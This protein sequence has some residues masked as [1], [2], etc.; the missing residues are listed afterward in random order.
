VAPPPLSVA[1]GER[2]VLFVGK[3]E[4]NKGAH[5]LLE[6]LRALRD[7]VRNDDRRQT[8]EDSGPWSVVRGPSSRVAVL[9]SLVIAGSGPLRAELERGLAALGVP[10]QFLDWAEHDETLRLMARCELL[11]FPSAWGEPLSRVLLEAAACGAP[12]A[13]M[14]TGGTRDIIE[15]GV[16]GALEPTPEHLGRRAAELLHD[17]EA[18]RRLGE[19]A[20]Q[21]VRER[22]AKDAVVRQVEDLYRSLLAAGTERAGL[23]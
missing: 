10:A 20:R 21:R 3:L 12:I 15:D 4:R 2:F 22:F 5:L 17:L 13:A 14:P 23:V 11:L 16:S 9:P 7:A 19:G 1:E 6:T 8:T 18:R